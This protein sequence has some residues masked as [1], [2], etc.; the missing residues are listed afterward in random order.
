ML[1]QEK[2]TV[3]RG[4]LGQL[5]ERVASRL[6]KAIEVDRLIGGTE[7]PHED[8]LKALRPQLRQVP[9]KKRMATPQRF[10]CRPFEDLL[11]D[12]MPKQKMRGRI[13]RASI[14]AVWHW[15]ANDLIPEPHKRLTADIREAIIKDRESDIFAKLEELWGAAAS[16]IKSALATEKK[17]ADAAR[18]LGS[19]I[20]AEDAAE[21]ALLISAGTDVI[22]LQ[23][24]LPRPI[25]ALSEIEISILRDTYD[26][27]L[28]AQP[29]LAPYVALIAKGR[30]ARPWE[31]LHLAAVLARQS[32]DTV[33]SNTDMGAVGELLF[34]DLDSYVE[35]ISAVRAPEFDPH[36]LVEALG[37]FAELSSGMVKE[38]GIRRDGKWGQHLTKAR[39]TVAQTMEG[40]IDRAPKEILTA[41]PGTK[42]GGGKGAKALDFSRPPDL[43]KTARAMRYAHLLAHAR[44]FA[45]AA[46]FNAKLSAALE[47]VS[48]ALRQFSEDLL[49]EVRTGKTGPHAEDY[50]ALTFGLCGLVLG[51]EETD[52]LRRRA[53]AA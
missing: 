23:G 44:P 19:P 4:F 3:L 2:Q 36:A 50:L 24:K 6:A 53:R 16:A 38:L 51:E 52:F 28:V 39:S 1:S 47:D 13:A 48:A 9:E 12:A 40:L 20:I 42:F 22:V 18:R 21:I 17:K 49:R 14:V 29:D 31:A 8:L 30:L 41:L 32:N 10:F 37:A 27:L 7:L 46:A 43:D 26:H 45:V 15:L 11:V 25:V 5:P 35:K 34:A 33:I